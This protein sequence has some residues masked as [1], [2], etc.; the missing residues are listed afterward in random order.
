MSEGECALVCQDIA[1]PAEGVT[2]LVAL[3]DLLVWTAGGNSSLRR[4]RVP[5]RRAFR[6]AALIETPTSVLRP[7]RS[8]ES[9]PRSITL[10]LPP[11]PPLHRQP[12]HT[13]SMS[14]TSPPPVET[15]PRFPLE[16]A[17]GEGETTWYG[18]PYECLVHLASP[19]NDPFTPFS[20]VYRGRG[21]TD[22]ATLYS[23]ASLMSVSA[24]PVILRTPLRGIFPSPSPPSPTQS[25]AS[26]GR[27]ASPA[28][29]DFSPSIGGLGS[30]GP[31]IG[32]PG[33]GGA[34]TGLSRQRTEF[35]SRE[36][37]AEAQPFSPTP[38][39][40]LVGAPGL[41][42]ATPLSNRVHALTVDT[43]GTVAVWDIIRAVCVGQFVR[44]DV[45]A[46]STNGSEHA[47]EEDWVCSPREAL[48][49]VRE[50]ID[51]EAVVV[52][53][54]ALD[55]STGVLNVHLDEHA[56]DAE[57]YA[58]ELG[59]TPDR[60]LP[61][62][63]G[64]EDVRSRLILCVFFRQSSD[65][66]VRAA[67]SIWASGSSETFSR[68]SSARN[69]T[70]M[71]GACV[72]LECRRFEGSATLP[73]RLRLP[74]NGIQLRTQEGTK[75]PPVPA[76]WSSLRPTCSPHYRITALSGSVSRAHRTHNQHRSR[77]RL[78]DRQMPR[79]AA[80]QLYSTNSNFR[81]SCL[82]SIR[83]RNRT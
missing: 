62:G 13:S 20:P 40:V 5:P 31:G 23:A 39:F 12:R 69:K 80:R 54:S 10:E 72:P 47:S 36:V 45:V 34:A 25:P 11:S 57:L 66:V 51:G 3:D 61:A 73:P 26:L 58:D 14:T 52:Q 37:V 77:C 78:Q 74:R 7:S 32:S 65:R 24:R 8:A 63:I 19:L 76:L 46:A 60:S 4:W 42:R 53:W 71:H 59:H 22:V 70:P 79:A 38:D 17:T 49:I 64:P 68:D 43:A 75:M 30:G 67:Q 2:K 16:D 55:T 50:R 41:V 33:A 9:R 83:A 44:E 6:A 15:S 56:F 18:L 21:D 35:E 48:D 82:L 28:H 29:S 1:P 81:R 27:P